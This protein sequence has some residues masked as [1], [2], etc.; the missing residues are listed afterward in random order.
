MAGAMRSGSER[1]DVTAVV[2]SRRGDVKVAGVRR[3]APPPEHD[4]T[5]LR[6]A[7]E[8]RCDRVAHVTHVLARAR[9]L[10]LL[11]DTKTAP[12][13]GD[14]KVAGVRRAAPPPEHDATNLRLA[15]EGRCDSLRH[16]DL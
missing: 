16:V 12:R 4:A 14:V 6:L 15:P 13:R 11:A 1:L 10:P 9:M 2:A 5:N 7:P 3:A 8:G